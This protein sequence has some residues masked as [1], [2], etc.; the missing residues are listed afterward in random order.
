MPH[1]EIQDVVKTFPL[2]VIDSIGTFA[3][4]LFDVPLNGSFAGT[5]RAVDG[6]TLNIGSGERV[7][8]IGP[9]GAGK[10]TLLHMIAGIAGPTSGRV[11]V[12]GHVTSVMTLGVGLREDL[13][14][15]EN[16]YVDGELQGKSRSDMELIISDIISFA[17]LEEFIDRPI[18]TY[19]TGMKAR[20]AFSMIAF[21]DPEILLIDE[22]LS[23]GDVV[24]SKKAAR[25][26]REIC[27]K[28]RIVVVVSHGL[29][30]VS[31]ICTR[32]IWMEAGRIRMDGSPLDVIQAYKK[33]VQE[34]AEREL[35]AKYHR[36][37]EDK[38]FEKGWEVS[39]LECF[40]EGEP[41]WKPVPIGER[42][43]LRW[44]VCRP[45]GIQDF[46]IRLLI[47]RLDGLL[48]IDERIE[49]GGPQ[50]AGRKVEQEVEIPP[51][52]GHGA[53]RVQVGI[54]LKD[55]KLASRSMVFEILDADPPKGGR[56]ALLS[57]YTVT[58]N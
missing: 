38:S 40:R 44:C 31:E 15:R 27:V 14:G 49:Y 13:T 52:L 33:S 50:F 41:W 6:V 34:T 54:L 11:S 5:R 7:G 55:I 12:D 21:I 24:F 17:E 2:G 22:A 58:T 20:L 1:I 8:I 29:D 23:V 30:V 43:S 10:S 32:C 39:S 37:I 4:I 26:I 42:F 19:S 45:G 51:M 9:N 57:R 18:R 25:R 56:P 16:I 48:I 36:Q 46:E 3:K 35:V 53:Y 28:G 47:E